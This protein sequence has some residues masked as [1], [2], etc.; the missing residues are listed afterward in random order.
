MA[1]DI[2]IKDSINAEKR[3]FTDRQFSDIQEALARGG[4]VK[5]EDIPLSLREALDLNDGQKIRLTGKGLE[6]FITDRNNEIEGRENYASNQDFIRISLLAADN[7]SNRRGFGRNRVLTPEQE[8]VEAQRVSDVRASVPRLAGSVTT[9]QPVSAPK[10]D[11]SGK[12]MV[13]SADRKTLIPENAV[14]ANGTVVDN[15]GELDY[16]GIAGLVNQLNNLL[17][18]ITRKAASLTPVGGVGVGVADTIQGIKEKQFSDNPLSRLLSD[19]TKKVKKS[20]AEIGRG[21]AVTLEDQLGSFLEKKYPE[22]TKLRPADAIVSGSRDKGLKRFSGIGE[23]KSPYGRFY[24][25]EDGTLR[26]L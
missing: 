17:R 3:L 13:L 16:G 5:A 14:V 2:S 20:V 15:P 26:K 12:K 24:I 21:E 6:N 19:T 7:L 4:R 8:Q 10:R 9:A 22:L 1:R 25:S 23:V 11:L 18:P